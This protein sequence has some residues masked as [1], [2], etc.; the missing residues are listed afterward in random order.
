MFV[1][2]EISKLSAHAQQRVDIPPFTSEILPLV[3]LPV[4]GQSCHEASLNVASPSFGILMLLLGSNM[5]V[6]ESSM[7]W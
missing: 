3:D 6:G 5:H 4:S 2:Q 1:F 7:L